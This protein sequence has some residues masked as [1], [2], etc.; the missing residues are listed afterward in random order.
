M[1]RTDRTDGRTE[2]IVEKR[3]VRPSSGCSAAAAAEAIGTVWAFCDL[4]LASS[5]IGGVSL[6]R[7]EDAAA[8][9]STTACS[10]GR[11]KRLL[12]TLAH[13]NGDWD[14]DCRDYIHTF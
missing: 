12:R 13:R 8:C 9:A 1:E 6:R 4:A 3:D 2:G 7:S 5:L 10:F 11:E 14:R